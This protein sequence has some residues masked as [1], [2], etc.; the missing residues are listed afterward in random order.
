M[1][2]P[3]LTERFYDLV[4]PD[5]PNEWDVEEVME[6]LVDKED[7]LCEAILGHIPV[8]WPV[9]HS[10]CYD[11]LRLVPNTLQHLSLE[12]I[13]RWLGITLDLYETDGLRAAQ[14]F[15]QNDLENYLDRLKGGGGLTLSAVEKQLL[16]YIRGI[17]RDNLLIAPGRR[18]SYTDTTSIV[19]PEELSHFDNNDHN[20]LLYKLILTFQ[21]G[22]I[23]CGSLLA[24]PPQGF[25]WETGKKKEN[26][27]WLRTFFDTFK[28]PL[29]ARDIY[30]T[31]ESIR[32]R[33]FLNTEL[34]G[35]MRAAEKR[36]FPSFFSSCEPHK[37]G[38]PL[39]TMQQALTSERSRI[40]ALLSPH[41][42]EEE[43]HTYCSNLASA[44]DSIKNTTR[45]YPLLQ[46]NEVEYQPLPPLPF[47]GV[48]K[49]RAVETAKKIREQKMGEQIV[50][51]MASHLLSL[52]P[53]ELKELLKNDQRD[54][55]KTG[56]AES[57]ITMIMDSEFASTVD[58][59]TQAPLVITINNEELQLPQRLRIRRIA[60][61]GSGTLWR[62]AMP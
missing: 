41:L 8:I 31:L 45:L 50:D 42:P 10:L 47:Q 22:F 21:W 13:P 9:S 20:F 36:L 26:S 52:S 23:T 15:M 43:C 56:L 59:E 30:H 44:A 1:K 29:L 6:P 40:G 60:S 16:P 61:K 51:M 54:S 4:A 7:A 24:N 55:G 3:R 5:I 19:V 53:K 39:H 37:S 2:L 46:Q 14:R 32:V 28:E 11:F 27:L 18:Q 49:L 12:Q 25:S 57:D 62:D 17:A 58:R 38:S 33:I 34:P 48:F 35:L